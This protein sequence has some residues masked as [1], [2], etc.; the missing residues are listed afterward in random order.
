MEKYGGFLIGVWE[1]GLPGGR[2]SG[3]FFWNDI[4]TGACFSPASTTSYFWNMTYDQIYPMFLLLDTLQSTPSQCIPSLSLA[5][6]SPFSNS[7]T[8]ST[9]PPSRAHIPTATSTAS[10]PRPPHRFL[11]SLPP[12]PQTNPTKN[13]HRDEQINKSSHIIH[14]P[15]HSL[16]SVREGKG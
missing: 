16:F 10:P 2:L 15:A 14:L 6:A 8:V 13:F 4:S 1:D 3:I 5:R 12:F 7:H 11:Q 9:N